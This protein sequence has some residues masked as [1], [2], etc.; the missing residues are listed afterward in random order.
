MARCRLRRTTPPDSCHDRRP[1]RR[2]ALC[3]SRSPPSSAKGRRCTA[4]RGRE[5]PGLDSDIHPHTDLRPDE[6]HLSARACTPLR[7][8]GCLVVGFAI[9]VDEEKAL[10]WQVLVDDCEGGAA[11]VEHPHLLALGDGR[12]FFHFRIEGDGGDLAHAE[13]Y[14]ADV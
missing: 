11:V 3:R 1:R 10:A 13:W 14:A 8:H 7:K 4:F 9:C 12:A 6:G 5:S 2:C